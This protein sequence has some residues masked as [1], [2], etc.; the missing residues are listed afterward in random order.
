[1]ELDSTILFGT[2]GTP[3]MVTTPIFADITHTDTIHTGLTDTI[4]T[5]TEEEIQHTT[6]SIEEIQCMQEI[7]R[8]QQQE[9]IE[10]R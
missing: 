10:E 9:T 1:M 8:I 3:G 7:T 2:L 6:D 4:I 5:D